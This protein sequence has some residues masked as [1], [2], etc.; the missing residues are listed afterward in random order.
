VNYELREGEKGPYA[1]VDHIFAKDEGLDLDFADGQA[2]PER[3]KISIFLK[4]F[5]GAPL[6]TFFLYYFCPKYTYQLPVGVH[7]IVLDLEKGED[8]VVKMEP[9]RPGL[10]VEF[11][12]QIVV[13]TPPDPA[14]DRPDVPLWINPPGRRVL[15]PYLQIVM[16][17]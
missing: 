17:V 2:I 9:E 5:P 12:G 1:L 6:A 8:F 13:S 16:M 11:S 15:G 14:G 4:S 3:V 10:K 7:P